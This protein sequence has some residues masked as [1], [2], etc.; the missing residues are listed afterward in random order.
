VISLR[1]PLTLLVGHAD[2][3]EVDL[4]NITLPSGDNS[5][6]VATVQAGSAGG[7]VFTI[8]GTLFSL[9]QLLQAML[10]SEILMNAMA[11]AD[12]ARIRELAANPESL[13]ANPA[14]ITWLAD[15]NNPI[16]TTALVKALGNLSNGQAAQGTATS[17]LAQQSPQAA[18]S[19]PGNTPTPTSTS[20][21]SGAAA[22]APKTSSAAGVG[23]SMLFSGTAMLLAAA[24]LYY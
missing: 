4:S 22:P 10:G 17:V 21:Q 6:R 1:F 12:V 11:P 2:G 14:T 3:N 13:M 15:I 19:T 23:G 8:Q 9:P 5:L 7:P 24:V 20:M 18:G 16:D